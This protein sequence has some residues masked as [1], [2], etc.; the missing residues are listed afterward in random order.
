MNKYLFFI[1]NKYKIV[2]ISR[3]RKKYTMKLCKFLDD[4]IGGMVSMTPAA[5]PYLEARR[6]KKTFGT[7]SNNPLPFPDFRRGK[8]IYI[9]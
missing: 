1:V 2:N 7:K 6:R 9:G 4:V 8:K 3:I 5:T